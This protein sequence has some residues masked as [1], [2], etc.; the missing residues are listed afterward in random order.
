MRPKPEPTRSSGIRSSITRNRIRPIAAGRTPALVASS[1]SDGRVA[2]AGRWRSRKIRWLR[3]ISASDTAG[4]RP[5]TKLA[6]SKWTTRTSDATT[7]RL[8]RR[9]AMRKVRSVSSE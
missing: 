6:C 1:G 8:P 4:G 7:A 2:S 3:R 9:S 5:L